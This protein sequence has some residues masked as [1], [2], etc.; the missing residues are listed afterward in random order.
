MASR[1]NVCILHAMLLLTSRYFILGNGFLKQ[2]WLGFRG[3]SKPAKSCCIWAVAEQFLFNWIL[4]Y[5]VPLPHLNC[6]T[7]C[8]LNECTDKLSGATIS[9]SEHWTLTTLAKQL[10][11]SARCPEQRNCFCLISVIFFCSCE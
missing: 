7:F 4:R 11:I 1:V 3:Q 8:S 9:G 6:F 10:D 2:Y 5:P